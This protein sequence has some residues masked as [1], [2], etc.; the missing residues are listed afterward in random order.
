MTM[1]NPYLT[2]QEASAQLGVSPTAFRRYCREGVIAYIEVSTRHWTIEGPDVVLK[3]QPYS[4]RSKQHEKVMI[5]DGAAADALAKLGDSL[6]ISQNALNDNFENTQFWQAFHAAYMQA[7][8]NYVWALASEP[9]QELLAKL[10][11]EAAAI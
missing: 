10:R 7:H 3:H 9:T 4:Q 1:T 6:N 11:D 5:F 2:V 8:F